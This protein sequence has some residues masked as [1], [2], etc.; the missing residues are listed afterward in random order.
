MGL[1]TALRSVL[2]DAFERRALSGSLRRA[3]DFADQS[4]ARDYDSAI[5][6]GANRMARNALL[7]E[8]PTIEHAAYA[9]KDRMSNI[10]TDY[11]PDSV[12]MPRNPFLGDSWAHHTHP[13]AN[14]PNVPAP[15]SDQDLSLVFSRR[16]DKGSFAHEV[17]GGGSFAARGS[18]GAK[19]KNALAAALDMIDNDPS[20]MKTVA[21]QA[22]NDPDAW[23]GLIPM[24]KAAKR[25]GLLRK[26]GYRPSN[27]A[28]ADLIENNAPLMRELE[29]MFLRRMHGPVYG[30]P[31]PLTW[32]RIGAG[33]GIGAAAAGALSEAPKR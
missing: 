12:T 13:M 6:K 19:G 21:S 9:A 18:K 7:G 28:Q 1:A 8:D 26:Y 27:A 10:T 23:I 3:T 2:A 20:F 14:G 25:L 4:L 11:S 22:G 17:E 29:G 30:L 24:G 33:A 16:Y 5:N 32:G 31:Y 15:L